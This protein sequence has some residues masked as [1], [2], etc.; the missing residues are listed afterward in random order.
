[1]EIRPIPYRVAADFINA[2]HRHHQAPQGMKWAVGLYDGDLLRGVATVGRPVSRMIDD[3][4]TC[5]ITRV[6]TDG[7]HNACSMLYGA[8]QRIAKAMGYKKIITYTLD[9]EDGSSVKAANFLYDGETDG[10]SWS[11]TS[12]KRHDDDRHLEQKKRWVRDL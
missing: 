8:C 9:S 7:M 11:R 4:L 6:C 3:G 2:N 10:G 5:E 1:M 12:R